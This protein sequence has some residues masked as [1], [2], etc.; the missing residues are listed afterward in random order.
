MKKLTLRIDLVLHIQYMYLVFASFLHAN[1]MLGLNNFQNKYIRS[2]LI[3]Q[4]CTVSIFVGG[5]SRLIQSGISPPLHNT[6][7]QTLGKR[8]L[9]EVTKA[10][11][12][13]E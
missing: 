3:C 5:K 11:S 6:F 12:A 9:V 10:P 13:A 2:F 4:M 7:P 8:M 1:S